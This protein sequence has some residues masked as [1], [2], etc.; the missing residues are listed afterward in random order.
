M[1]YPFRTRWQYVYEKCG[2]SKILLPPCFHNIA[3]Q[4]PT[5]VL[6]F[7]SR[8]RAERAKLHSDCCA[9][10]TDTFGSCSA[11]KKVSNYVRFLSKI[12]TYISIQN[13]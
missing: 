11:Q 10:K 4:L 6:S 7:E 1:V 3:R 9:Y 8:T 12:L 5:T 13:L 2:T